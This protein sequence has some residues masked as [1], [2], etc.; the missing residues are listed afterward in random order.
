[1]RS[2]RTWIYSVWEVLTTQWAVV[3]EKIIL[4]K[5]ER[6]AENV[7][8]ICIQNMWQKNPEHNPSAWKQV[9]KHS[10]SPI[11]YYISVLIQ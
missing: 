8:P 5:T 11:K 7:S 2:G 1:M 6:A 3:P 9:R 10:I 4:A